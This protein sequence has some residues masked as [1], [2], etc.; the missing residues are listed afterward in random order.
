MS[1]KRNRPS[2]IDLTSGTTASI[3]KQEFKDRGGHRGSK[4]EPLLQ[5]VAKL[6]AGECY[7][8]PMPKGASPRAVHNRISAALRRSDFKSIAR[9]GCEYYK[10]TTTDGKLAIC[11]VR[12]SK[13]E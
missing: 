10:R 13:T 6:H 8:L 3:S 11:C 1:K 7:V 12:S 2:D 5:E 9:A 4:Y